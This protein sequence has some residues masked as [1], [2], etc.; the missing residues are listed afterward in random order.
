M[1]TSDSA[2][3]EHRSEHQ[4]CQAPAQRRGRQGDGNDAGFA[5]NRPGTA[6]QRKMTDM[7]HDSA[8]AAQLR[9]LPQA[10]AQAFSPVKQLAAETPNR[11]GLPNQLKAGVEALSGMSLDQVKVH[12]NSPQPAQLNAHAYAQG[13]DIHVA[14]GQEKHLPH[15]AWH[16]VQ[17]AQGRVR[18]TRQMKS[19]VAVNDDAGLEAEADMMGAKAMQSGA[20]QMAA[21]GAP[22]GI[23]HAAGRGAP[24][25]MERAAPLL[26]N[27]R[28]LL[29]DNDKVMK[30]EAR[31][32]DANLID[33][34]Y[35]NA[36][37]NLLLDLN[38]Q[39][40]EELQRE[41]E[42]DSYFT[43]T[44]KG[45][46][47]V[48]HANAGIASVAGT[49]TEDTSKSTRI[50]TVMG[51]IKA[52][53]GNEGLTTH[54]LSRGQF[55][56]GMLIGNDNPEVQRMNIG[57]VKLL[58]M[59]ETQAPYFGGSVEYAKN[60]KDSFEYWVYHLSTLTKDPDRA[61]TANTPG[62]GL[63]KPMKDY[64]TH[65]GLV[66]LNNQRNLG[67]GIVEAKWAELPQELRA[68]M[69]GK[70]NYVLTQLGVEQFPDD[71]KARLD[72][73]LKGGRAL[74]LESG[75]RGHVRTRKP[76]AE[77]SAGEI[78]TLWNGLGEDQKKEL[79]G[80][81][82]QMPWSGAHLHGG[83]S[84]EQDQQHSVLSEDVD[85]RR[86][87]YKTTPGL[88]NVV[89]VR[90]NILE[91]PEIAGAKYGAELTK[92]YG[93][94]SHG[95][96][97]Q[98]D[99]T[100]HQGDIDKRVGD[101]VLRN[102]LTIESLVKEFEDKH[103]DW[104]QQAKRAHKPIIGGM[105]G[106]TL[107]YLNLYSEAQMRAPTYDP[108][109]PSMEALRASMLGALIGDKRHHSYDE[110]MAASVGMPYRRS[111][112]VAS[113]HYFFRG[114]YDD[115]LQSGEPKIKSVAKKA[116]KTT[117]DNGRYLASGDHNRIAHQIAATVEYDPAIC[118]L[119]D[120]IIAR[121]CLVF[122]LPSYSALHELNEKIRKKLR[123]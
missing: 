22:A 83:H 27:E 28:D 44:L 82:T 62:S 47:D 111:N 58:K 116:Q 102:Y 90:G 93:N 11:T 54:R 18:A 20:V 109:W 33:T 61:Y 97:P 69:H 57:Y 31:T 105:S 29:K 76:M 100:G 34:T 121:H 91:T 123:G 36:A 92:K 37:D 114:D 94:P 9:E 56:L 41:I 115:V 77:I 65:K 112:S 104:F 1:R 59:L 10:P 72:F 98:K 35:D 68:K 84:W 40:E 107:G 43:G 71:P 66:P 120:Q 119:L 12:Y 110:V 106:H 103:G 60:V 73:Y 53:H 15:E 80:D 117:A 23:P 95:M 39:Y 21:I 17:Q 78:E 86:L 108:G 8:R 55:D 2:A 70:L 79:Y 19:G 81:V 96:V 13:R 113:L 87:P 48:I 16:V 24:V 30:G 49:T 50:D 89:G 101:H 51:K 74:R 88:E 42:H 5:D 26:A 67:T 25:Q 45:A 32:M 38:M 118:R 7:M 85:F 46:V 64:R 75:A 14:P 99:F 63:P 6:L 122:G 52:T 3:I 4:G